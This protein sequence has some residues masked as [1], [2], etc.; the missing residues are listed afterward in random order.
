[1]MFLDFLNTSLFSKILSLKSFENSRGSFLDILDINSV[2]PVVKRCKTP[3]HYKQDYPKTFFVLHKFKF[4]NIA[5]FRLTTGQTIKKFA[6]NGSSK[7]SK[8]ND[9]N[10]ICQ[11]MPT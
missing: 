3:K 11:K 7:L 4:L 6:T 5:L 8:V 9:L 10:P 1:M 2:L